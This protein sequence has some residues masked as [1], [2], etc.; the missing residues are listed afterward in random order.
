LKVKNKQGLHPHCTYFEFVG[1]LNR[2]FS[3]NKQLRLAT[4]LYQVKTNKQ[5]AWLVCLGLEF[6]SPR[7]I[8]FAGLLSEHN[9]EAQQTRI[10]I[11]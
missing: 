10:A 3:N 9:L 2:I 8:N 5:W 11:H 7:K 1:A 4:S 6:L